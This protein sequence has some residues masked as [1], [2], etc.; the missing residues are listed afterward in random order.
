M[1]SAPTCVAVGAP[2]QGPR[3]RG[4]HQPGS[5][6]PLPGQ[7]SPTEP[8]GE[9]AAL[10]PR[11]GPRAWWRAAAGPCPALASPGPATQGGRECLGPGPAHPHLSGCRGPSPHISV[12]PGRVTAG[13]SDPH[14]TASW[15]G[16]GWQPGPTGP[17]ACGS[18]LPA[19]HRPRPTTERVHRQQAL[20]SHGRA[21]SSAITAGV[22]SVAQL[23][24]DCGSRVAWTPPLPPH[25]AGRGCR[26]AGRAV[27]P[28]PR[29]PHLERA[30]VACLPSGGEVKRGPQSG[31]D[32]PPAHP[33]LGLGPLPAPRVL[34][35]HPGRG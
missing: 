33:V 31:T 22:P 5:T 25:A 7:G 3:R 27:P 34:A 13:R 26:D 14:A 11:P 12:P 10:A 29:S 4:A 8:S 9:A 23:P 20:G 19:V 30:G 2:T 21:V 35:W 15:L 17:P 32:T 24:Q 1:C 18:G 16:W 28:E 6:Q